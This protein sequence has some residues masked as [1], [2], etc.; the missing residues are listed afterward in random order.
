M[1]EIDLLDSNGVIVS[2]SQADP[3]VW[4]GLAAQANQLAANAGF[5]IETGPLVNSPERTLGTIG[6]VQN[7]LATQNIGTM[8]CPPNP[9]PP[10]GTTLWPA[11]RPVNSAILAWAHANLKYPKGTVI[12]DN[13]GGDDVVAR[14]ET[15][16]HPPDG[17]IQPWGCH[18]GCTIYAPTAPLNPS[19]YGVVLPV[20]GSPHDTTNQTTPD[21]WVSAGAQWYDSA[22]PSSTNWGIVAF[23][24]AALLLVVGGFWA[25]IQ[26]AGRPRLP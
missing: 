13:V 25:A 7:W 5:D 8:P 16:Y 26:L 6:D 19:S 11:N 18:K 17:P 3:D 14:L 21:P 9:P 1:I 24:G 2:S 23:T 4:T 15:H 12:T 22:P 20:A 10:A